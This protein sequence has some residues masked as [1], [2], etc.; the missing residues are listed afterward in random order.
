MS[1][2]RVYGAQTFLLSPQIVTVEVD[3][4]RGLH[5]FS[6]V[7]LPDK[8]V[9]EA[10]DRVSSA[11]KHAGFESPKSL[12]KKI[13]VS[14]APADLKKEGPL[15]D[16]P[17]ALSYL[18]ASG[19]IAFEPEGLLFAGE[20]SLDGTLRAVRG[21]LP[22]VAHAK[23]RGFTAVFVP[24]ENAREAALVDGIAVFGAASLADVVRHLNTKAAK[25]ALAQT[26][27]TEI[28]DADESAD[29]LDHIHGQA[30]AKR[31]LMIAGAG[32]HHVGLWGPPGT[33]KTL[34]ARALASILPPLSREEALEVTGIHSVAGAL[35][36]DLMVRPPMRSPHHTSSYVSLV[37]GGVYPKPGEITLAH[38]GVL[39][40][41][42]FPEFDRRVIE[43][44]RQPLEERVVSIARAKGTAQFP[45]QIS[46][47]VAMNPCPCGNFGSSKVCICPANTL[48]RYQ[49]KV[50]GPIADR[51]DL[52]VP[53]APVEFSQLGS[54][55]AHVGE[56]KAARAKVA[57]ARARQRE[58][59]A[60]S[61]KTLNSELSAR[62]IQTFAPL[63]P[64]VR[65]LLDT[66]AERLSLSPRSYHRVIKVAR[67]IAD[68][69]GSE[70]IEAPHI[71]EAIEYR[72][73]D[74]LKQ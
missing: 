7:G 33:G 57:S 74:F 69:D 73:R 64:A 19:D 6:V 28:P 1:Y 10:R 22:L 55:T 48:S 8:A 67:T 3:L 30:H 49:R 58:R 61:G 60:P 34:L 43:A 32:G 4:S 26:P 42:E 38:R 68:L 29:A 65:K 13:V 9:E 35:R 54:A 40:L 37:G 39:F 59:L 5:S 70:T 24:Q 50:S 2:A 31:A 11:I 23:E 63:A 46:L 12:N 27:R 18:L 66:A 17:I 14:L 36:E 20:L 45:A 71:L 53:V 72:P 44:L 51:I 15:F 62:D 16:L 21:V 25:M 56:T 47:V 52:W 41:D